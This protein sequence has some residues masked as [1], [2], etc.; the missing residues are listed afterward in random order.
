MAK[1]LNHSRTGTKKRSATAKKSTPKQRQAL[2]QEQGG[3]TI[4]KALEGFVCE[5]D[6]LADTLPLAGPLVAS[7]LVETAKELTQFLDRRCKKLSGGSFSIPPEEYTEFF[8]LQRRLQRSKRA[9]QIIP[10]SF[11]TSL[12]SQYDAFVGTLMRAV[13]YM[14][15]EVLNSSEHHIT[16]KDLTAFVSLDAARE[17]VVEKEVESLLRESHAEQFRWMEAKFNVPLTK[18]L[19]SWPKFIE[20]TERRNLFVHCN[21]IVS[22]QYLAVCKRHGADCSNAK[23]GIE[24]HVDAGY[25]TS[26]YATLLEI[27]IKLAHVLWRRL[28]PDEMDKADG[29]FNNLCLDFIKD[30]K[31]EV[32][33]T[34]LDFAAEYK[35]FGSESS[36]KVLVLN[37][38]QT[39]KWIGQEK[40]AIE[41]LASEDWNAASEKFQLGA[42][43]LKDDFKTASTLMK[44]IGSDN[45]PTKSD[46]REWPMF[47]LFRATPEFAAT[48]QAVFG[49][50][51]GKVTA[52]EIADKKETAILPLPEPK[53]N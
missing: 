3:P 19:P 37:R 49:E 21:G 44:H 29:N 33:R 38:A 50:S 43:V 14:K 13:F 1:S 23:M 53:P 11:F 18:D 30:E 7:S 39:Y 26:A 5:V 40:R 41:I 48:Y 51:F 20:V 12:V 28:K 22:A 35:K 15:P 36:R 16:F 2:N 47:K 46:Y 9:I 6:A 45:S 25:F 34:L 4:A 42:A 27:G 24:L 10:R 17:S 32:A 31:Y 52:K 8:N